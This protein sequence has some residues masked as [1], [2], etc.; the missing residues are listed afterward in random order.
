[1]YIKNRYITSSIR[2]MQLD[3]EVSH[4]SAQCNDP[5][6]TMTTKAMMTWSN[7]D[8]FYVTRPL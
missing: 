6:R 5:Y 3:T 4:G 2:Q 7:G 1:M 8:F